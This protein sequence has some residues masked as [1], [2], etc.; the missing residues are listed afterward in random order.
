MTSRL[1]NFTLNRMNSLTRRFNAHQVNHLYSQPL[2]IA[3][4]NSKVKE[5]Q[6]DETISEKVRR[7]GLRARTGQGL[8]TTQCGSVPNRR[9]LLPALGQHRSL[10]RSLQLF[11]WWCL[12]I[13][14]ATIILGLHEVFVLRA[15]AAWLALPCLWAVCELRC[16]GALT[17]QSAALPGRSLQG[18]AMQGMSIVCDSAGMVGR[19]AVLRELDF[20]HI[21]FIF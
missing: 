9:H 13:C 14:L 12:F 19:G 20:H 5:Q 6:E 7:R 11:F 8:L 1:Q 2:P 4:V 21:V 18:S 17:G 15:F 10:P 3:Q 16:G